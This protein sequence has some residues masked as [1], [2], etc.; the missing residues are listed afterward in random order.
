MNN[1]FRSKNQSNANTV[2]E[3]W[4]TL[5]W[6]ASAVLTGS[7]ITIGR[8]V[9]REGKSNPR[10]CHDSCEEILHLLCGELTHS[11]G[12]E[13]IEMVAGDTL[14]IPSGVFHNAMN[15]GETSA[16][17]IVAYSKGNRDFRMET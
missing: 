8:V 3:D 15:R 2:V 4:G 5:T 13:S 17:M 6:L 10:H 12:D 9:I 14:I 11:I 7:D 16:E 1:Q